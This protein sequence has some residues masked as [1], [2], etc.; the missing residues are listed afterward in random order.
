MTMKIY[1]FYKLLLIIALLTLSCCTSNISK[2]LD[3]RDK[4]LYNRI[5]YRPGYGPDS[6]SGSLAKSSNDTRVRIT[7]DSYYRSADRKPTRRVVKKKSRNVFSVPYEPSSRHYNNPYSF[8][9]PLNFPYFD[10]DQY[11]VP[12]NGYNKGGHDSHFDEPVNNSS[13]KKG[14]RRLY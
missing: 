14:S 8:K 5:G 12:P 3:S 13:V 7:P 6:G 2:S 10:A 1:S 11:Y 4:G 9:P